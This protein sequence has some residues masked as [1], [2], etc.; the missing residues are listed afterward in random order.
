MELSKGLRSFGPL[1]NF[2]ALRDGKVYDISIKGTDFA[3][4]ISEI[5][6]SNNITFDTTPA[7]LSILDPISG[8]FV[9]SV[10]IFYLRAFDWR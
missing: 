2:I 3:G 5:T 9:N 1:E 8:S 6:I 10:D 4:N 7:T